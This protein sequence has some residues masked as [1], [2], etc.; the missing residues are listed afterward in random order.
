MAKIYSSDYSSLY[1]RLNGVRTKHGLAPISKS[2]SGIA[3]ASSMEALRVD[4]Y[5]TSVASSYIPDSTYS[6]EFSGAAV[7]AY[8]K[9]ITLSNVN[10]VI[11]NMDNICVHNGSNYSS[12]YGDYS[13]RDR[14]SDCNT[15]K[16]SNDAT[17]KG[18]HDS[19]YSTFKARDGANVSDSL[20]EHNASLGN[21]TDDNYR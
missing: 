15:N 5:N 21:T 11:T 8:I 16:S 20:K 13:D 7:G 17:Y 19:D 1:T 18:S 14:D 9:Q 4:L 3:R 10:G 6:A 12:N 2:V